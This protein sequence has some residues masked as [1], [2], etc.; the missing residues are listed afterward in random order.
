MSDQLLTI[1]AIRLDAGHVRLRLTGDL[2][3]DTAPELTAAAAALHG[4]DEVL[5]DLTGVGICDSSG[6]SALLV[7]QRSAGAIRLTGVSPQLQ[8]MLDRTGLAELLAIQHD[9]DLRATG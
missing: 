4:D 5:V 9:D 8:R 1:E 7:M 2:D 3:Y 6:L